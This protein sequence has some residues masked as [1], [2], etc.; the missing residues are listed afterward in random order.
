MFSPNYLQTCA[1]QD[2]RNKNKKLIN[3]YHSMAGNRISQILGSEVT[4][5]SELTDETTLDKILW[6]RSSALG[7][8]LWADPDTNYRGAEFRILLHR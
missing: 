2:T 7:E 4:S 1:K 6:P 8:R 5:W 3:N